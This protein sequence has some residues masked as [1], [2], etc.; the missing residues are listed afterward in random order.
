MEPEPPPRA[1]D[2]VLNP[3]EM[4]PFDSQEAEEG[5]ITIIKPTKVV[6]GNMIII[7]A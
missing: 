2:K 5:S 6:Y 1:S 4:K 3:Q 7:K